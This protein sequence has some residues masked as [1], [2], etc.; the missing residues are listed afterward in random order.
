[1]STRPRARKAKSFLERPGSRTGHR[2]II[3]LILLVL[4]RPAS[5]YAQTIPVFDKRA[6]FSFLEAQCAFGPR[7]PG[8][9]SHLRC[10][11]YL[12]KTLSGYTDKV[13]VQPFQL[14][15]GPPSRTVEAFNIIAKFRPELSERVLLCAHWDSRPWADEDPDPKFHS[16][17]VLGAND[18]ASG[19]AVLL[20]LARIFHAQAPPVGIDLVLF[21]GEDAGDTENTWSWAR[22]SQYFAGHLPKE[23]HPRFVVLVDMIG[24]RDLTIP[25]EAYSLEYAPA[26]MARVWEIA[27][28][29]KIKSLVPER[30][31]A[32]MDDHIPFLRLGIPAIDLVDLDYPHW[33]TSQDTPDKCSPDS[34]DDVGRL[35]VQLIYAEARLFEILPRRLGYLLAAVLLIGMD[36][37]C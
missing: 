14:S 32:V 11:D 10:R 7:V 31:P 18:G 27:A 21:D 35:L 3:L 24:D 12:V 5:P 30:G 8:S 6:A 19:V 25:Q 36:G 29:L 26:L 2:C 4:L 34:L 13:E 9:E 20:E 1:M 17:P 15:F 22:G 33:H 28:A 37:S 16:T 23:T